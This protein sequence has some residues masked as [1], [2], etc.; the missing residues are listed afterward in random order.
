MKIKVCRMVEV[1]MESED[2]GICFNESMHARRT[3]KVKAGSKMC[4]LGEIRR[5]GAGATMEGSTAPNAHT[6]YTTTSWANG[7]GSSRS[8]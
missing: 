7:R 5:G 6:S 8:T 4:S 1:E 2:E 3:V